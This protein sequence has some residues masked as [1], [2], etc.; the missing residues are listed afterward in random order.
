MVRKLCRSSDIVLDFL[1]SW[2]E[3]DFDAVTAFDDGPI[4]EDGV[5]HHHI[6]QDV[7]V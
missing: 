1:P 3:T 4:D 2:P 7:I 5:S 6:E